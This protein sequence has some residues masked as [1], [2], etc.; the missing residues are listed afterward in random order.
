MKAKSKKW[1]VRGYFSE[2][3]KETNAYYE[4]EAET[5]KEAERI[6]EARARADFP[7]DLI[8]GADFIAEPYTRER[9]WGKL[10]LV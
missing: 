7:Y 2:N 4:V 5:E 3:E 9:S 1:I 8:K 6:G 10:W